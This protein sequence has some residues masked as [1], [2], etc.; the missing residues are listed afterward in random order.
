MVPKHTIIF[1]GKQT[2]QFFFFSYVTA[3]KQRETVSI[4]ALLAVRQITPLL[5]HFYFYFSS[6]PDA[7]HQDRFMLARS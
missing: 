3:K 6:L 2:I 4:V 1:P 5:A 7:L